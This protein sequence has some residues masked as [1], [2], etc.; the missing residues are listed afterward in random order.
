[1]HITRESVFQSDEGGGR[2]TAVPGAERVAPP[3]HHPTSRG[4]KPAASFRRIGYTACMGGGAVMAQMLGWPF[5]R[6]MVR[7]PHWRGVPER[8]AEERWAEA[9]AMLVALTGTVLLWGP[10][11]L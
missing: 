3:N 1:M 10:R 6:R 4:T 8:S 11:P 7:L 2:N 5:S 9:A